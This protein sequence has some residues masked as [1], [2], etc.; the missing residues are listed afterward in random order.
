[1]KAAE[2]VVWVELCQSRVRQNERNQA[3]ATKS[4]VSDKMGRM[5]N[6]IRR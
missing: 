2:S 4:K 1:M 5:K 3:N 6:D